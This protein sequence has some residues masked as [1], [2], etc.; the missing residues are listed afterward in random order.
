MINIADDLAFALSHVVHLFHP[1]TII[2]GG[3]LSLLGDWLRLPVA[4]RLTQYVMHAFLPPPLV[5]IAAL[6]ENVVPI[7]ALELAKKA[8]VSTTETQHL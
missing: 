3:G 1:Q 4:E 5:Q 7:G 2:M 6:R 8:Y